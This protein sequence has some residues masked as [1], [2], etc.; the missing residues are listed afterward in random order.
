MKKTAE[1]EDLQSY[2]EN[3]K[4]LITEYILLQKQAMRLSAI[5][6]MA[7]FGGAILERLVGFILI[8]LVT[9][10]AAITLGF[11][12]SSIT[13]SLTAGFGLVTIGLI[14][15]AILIHLGRNRLFVNPLVNTLITKLHE[16]PSENHQSTDEKEPGNN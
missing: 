5:R 10:F 1:A 13:G 15:L 4:Q 11:W 3:M 14:L 7:K 16:H 2:L 6:Y 9:L 8:A 12:L